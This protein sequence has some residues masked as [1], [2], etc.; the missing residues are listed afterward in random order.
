MTRIFLAIFTF[1]LYTAGR[2]KFQFHFLPITT[3]PRQRNK[4]R[5][6]SVLEAIIL[7]Y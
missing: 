1:L 4:V 3:T 2:N 6:C 5:K 7:D